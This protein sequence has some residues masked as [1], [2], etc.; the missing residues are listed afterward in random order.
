MTAVYRD[1]T[2]V[3]KQTGLEIDGDEGDEAEKDRDI[4]R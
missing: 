4:Y 3:Q 2:A 1:N